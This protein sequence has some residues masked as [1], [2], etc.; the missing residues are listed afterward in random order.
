MVE[1]VALRRSLGVRG[2][3]AAFPAP[4]RARDAVSKAKRVSLGYGAGKAVPVP[5]QSILLPA[6]IGLE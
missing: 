5:P 6:W 2:H 1:L 4:F 3:V